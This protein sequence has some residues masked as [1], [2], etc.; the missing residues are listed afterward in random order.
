MLMP[1][2]IGAELSGRLRL[3][4]DE[5]RRMLFPLSIIR[6]EDLRCWECFDVDWGRDIA[7]EVREYFIPDFSDWR[8]PKAFESAVQGLIRDLR[9]T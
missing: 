7:V 6:F 4:R 8:D 1:V 9:P 3:E 2:L 5:H